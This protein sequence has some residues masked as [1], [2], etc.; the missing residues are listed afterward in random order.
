MMSD[1]ISGRYIYTSFLMESHGSP[2]VKKK[3]QKKCFS[4]VPSCCTVVVLKKAFLR[5]SVM[6]AFAF[7]F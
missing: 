6:V 1:V 3:K 4:N 2:D 7:V 5:I